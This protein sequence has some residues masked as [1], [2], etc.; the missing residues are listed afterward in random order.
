MDANS[1]FSLRH[2]SL[3]RILGIHM[4][5]EFCSLGLCGLLT[6]SLIWIKCFSSGTCILEGTCRYLDFCGFLDLC[7]LI[8]ASNL[9]L[10]AMV[11]EQEHGGYGEIMEGMIEVEG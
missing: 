4:I 1:N 8:L 6:F 2:I 10:L 9:L 3:M 7:F 5:F 11:W